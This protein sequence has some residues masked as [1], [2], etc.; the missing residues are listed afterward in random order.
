MTT[1]IGN[2]EENGYKHVCTLH[3]FLCWWI[4]GGGD[5]E[6]VRVRDS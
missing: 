2:D 4:C 6:E 5:E 3:I 1:D